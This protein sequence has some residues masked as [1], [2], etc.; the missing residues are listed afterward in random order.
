MGRLDGGDVKIPDE[1]GWDS[2]VGN[3]RE[4]AGG[5]VFSSSERA[6]S[7]PVVRLGNGKLLG[8]EDGTPDSPVGDRPIAFE[9]LRLP[10]SQLFCGGSIGVNVLP[11]RA[12]AEPK[13]QLFEVGC[14][15][16]SNPLGELDRC[17]PVLRLG[18]SNGGGCPRKPCDEPLAAFGLDG[19]APVPWERSRIEFPAGGLADDGELLALNSIRIRSTFP[20]IDGGIV[21]IND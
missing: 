12:A 6:K 1:P 20:R 14:D 7:T 11:D 10:R 3:D 13:L 5:P 18:G 2:S 17:P 15:E 9:S 16:R 21:L 4:K 19:G 8:D